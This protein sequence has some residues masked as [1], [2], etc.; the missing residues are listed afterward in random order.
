MLGAPVTRWPTEPS[1]LEVSYSPGMFGTNPWRAVVAENGEIALMV[2]DYT[3]TGELRRMY[4]QKLASSHV[5]TIRAVLS[6]IEFGQLQPAYEAPGTD[7]ETLTIRVGDHPVR[8][9][10][11]NSCAIRRR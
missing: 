5:T 4:R 10:G 6:R 11:H 3:E 7:Q 9:Y 2:S 1:W 8:V